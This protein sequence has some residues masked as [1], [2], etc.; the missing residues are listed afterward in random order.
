MRIRK[1][2][3]NLGIAL[4]VQNIYYWITELIKKIRWGWR[5]GCGV[6]KRE[7]LIVSQSKGVSGRSLILPGATDMPGWSRSNNVSAERTNEHVSLGK[8]LFE[9]LPRRINFIS[10][11]NSP[12]I[13]PWEYSRLKH[14]LFS[15]Y[16]RCKHTVSFYVQ[17]KVALCQ[18]LTS[19]TSPTRYATA[20]SPFDIIF[21]HRY[22]LNGLSRALFTLEIPLKYSE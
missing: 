18:V 7:G 3:R 15:F 6:E 14:T 10:L 12:R 22:I 4:R 9:P 20:H 13:S 19:A 2:C 11:S 1:S 17:K 8:S 21:I 16:N 5:G